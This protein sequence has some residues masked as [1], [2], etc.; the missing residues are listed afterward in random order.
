MADADGAFAPCPDPA[1]AAPAG[2]RG[3]AGGGDPW[4]F[5]AAQPARAGGADAAP[6]AAGGSGTEEISSPVSGM[7]S[8]VPPELR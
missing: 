8:L 2:G 1:Q 4:D 5:V 3:S 6:G 7:Q